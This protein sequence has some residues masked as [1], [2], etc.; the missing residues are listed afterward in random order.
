MI[1]MLAPAANMTFAS[2][3]SGSTYVSDGNGLIVISNNSVPDQTA[4]G[5]AGCKTLSPLGDWGSRG[6]ILLSDL[7]AYDTSSKLTQY[8]VASVFADP[9]TANNGTW[10]KGGTGTGA[11]NWTQ[12]SPLTLTQLSANLGSETVARIAA[13]TAL[14][15]QI[16]GLA[17]PVQWAAGG[18]VACATT[19]S[20]ALSGEQ[21]ID[22]VTTSNSRVLVWQ[23][24]TPANN[25]IYI[26][27]S[28]SWSRANDA[29]LATE[30]GGIA[31]AVN[32]G[33][34]YKGAVFLLPLSAAQINLGTTALNFLQSNA[35]GAASLISSSVT[36]VVAPSGGNFTSVAAALAFLANA[37]IG[38]GV[39][40]NI[41]V[42]DGT[43]SINSPMIV[44]GAFSRNIQIYGQHTY[45]HNVTSI[46]NATGTAGAWSLA[47]NLDSVSNI[48]IGDY[49]GIQGASGGTNASYLNGIFPVTAVDT[50]NNRITIASTH[51]NA[52]P[53]SG[54][55]TAASLNFKT[56]FSCTNCDCFE[57]FNGGTALNIDKVAII[58]DG[59]AHYGINVQDV[60][61]CY[62]ATGVGCYGFGGGGTGGAG[63]FANYNSEINCDGTLYAA[64]CY[65]GINADSGASID[66]QFAITNGNS[67]NGAI[68]TA[69]LIRTHQS[70]T[71]FT[72]NGAQ[73]IYAQLN[74]CAIVNSS[75]ASGNTHRGYLCDGQ[76]FISNSGATSLNNGNTDSTSLS[77]TSLS[78][79]AGI[80]A[81]GNI[82]LENTTAPPA[83]GA[84][85]IGLLM[86]TTPHFGIFFGTG[87][88]TLSAAQ[89]S[90]YLRRDGNSTT[91]RT[92]VNTDGATNW[93]PIT[94]AS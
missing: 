64:N 18:Y 41:Q 82:V 40:V 43:Y 54:A 92:Y 26:S 60:G 23:Q 19:G 89:G 91:S 32:G 71:C 77:T 67:Q 51:Q 74:G 3:P 55:V 72:G 7:Y 83:G 39:L 56:I 85:D 35:L 63:F 53:P 16:T 65:M 42:N 28:G 58:G 76:S 24:G 6:F 21:T 93:T 61:R 48:A 12:G 5:Q 68:C 29:N 36:Y 81:N 1:L 90:L 57:V 69:A 52:V 86:G 45:A 8:T 20:I 34:L 62:I 46:Q 27:S 13:D 70:G 30:L 88:P 17:S 33:S 15:A 87:A 4:L 78:L 80:V 14:Q 10:F 79:S 50:V 25:G 66:T 49:V 22:G 2:L 38:S 84:Q 94:T 11:G 73:G 37:V 59:T 9:T 31:V 47:L 75:T 44:Q